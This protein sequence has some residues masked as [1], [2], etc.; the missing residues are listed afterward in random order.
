MCKPCLVAAPKAYNRF[1][2]LDDPSVPASAPDSQIG[3]RLREARLRRG[4]GVRELARD[5]GVSAS[6]LSAIEHGRSMPSVKTLY[7]LA[8]Q[9]QVSLDEL[10]VLGT[11]G[12]EEAPPKKGRVST[13]PRERDSDGVGTAQPH[14]QG[15]SRDGTPVYRDGLRPTLTM[16]TGVRWERLA[17]PLGADVEFIRGHYPVGSATAPA[18]GLM[19]H[20]GLEFGYVERGRLGVTVGFETYEVGAGDSV[21]FD[22]NTPHRLF[23][24]GDEPATVIWF[25]VGR[26]RDGRIHAGSA[27]S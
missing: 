15:A 25:V 3:S 10:F 13:S 20:G 12:D 23:A 17:E 27:E 21:A 5:L 22:S 4:L 9:L 14:I 24:V 18:D 19:Q 2:V 8:T 7:G 11:A 6:L 1:M 16:D 26:R